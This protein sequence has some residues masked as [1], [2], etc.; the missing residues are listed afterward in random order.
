MSEERYPIYCANYSHH[1][2]MC[3]CLDTGHCTPETCSFYIT[4]ER[5]NETLEQAY[6][7]L[8]SLPKEEQDRI[9]VRYYNGGYPW[10]DNKPQSSP[11]DV[12]M[13]GM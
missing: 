5:A 4:F 2:H 6:A 7:R 1:K 9:S 3:N 13:Y 10:L 8:R 12:V 11:D